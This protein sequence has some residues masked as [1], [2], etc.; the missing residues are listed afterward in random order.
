[1]IQ[2]WGRVPV[3]LLDSLDIEDY[4][5]AI[6]GT[7]D[8]LMYPLLR[9]GSLVQI[10]E[11]RREIQNSGW[12]NEF[13][14]PIY[15]LE[16]RDAYACGWCSRDGDHLV[17]QP[18]P[19]SPSKPIV[20]NYRTDVDVVGQIVGVAMQLEVKKTENRARVRPRSVAVRG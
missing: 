18:H 12:T 15:F 19:G 6:I 16:L 5:Y 1:M 8:Y 20:L 13:D 10:D 11:R 3:S 17:L 4:R 9:P 7:E 2:Q 14:R